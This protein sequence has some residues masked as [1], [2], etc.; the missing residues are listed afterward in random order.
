MP[1]CGRTRLKVERSG[2]AVVEIRL[3]GQSAG[4]RRAKMDLGGGNGEWS[5]QRLLCTVERKDAILLLILGIFM[6]L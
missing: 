1:F 3:L 6:V 5:A 4:I 2:D